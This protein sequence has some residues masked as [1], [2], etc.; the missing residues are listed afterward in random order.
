MKRLLM[1]GAGGI[2]GYFGGRL[3][4]NGVDVTFLV[5]EGRR[6]QL[7]ERGL[8]IHSVSGDYTCEPKLIVTGE[9]I[10]PYD[11]IFITVK[12]Y[13]LKEC[14]NDIEPY[15]GENT[16]IVPLL[17]GVSHMNTLQERFGRERVLGG[18][19]FIE[20]TLNEGGDIV[21]TSPANR[22]VY[23]EWEGGSSER[24]REL[25][26]LLS[27]TKANIESSSDIAGEMWHKYLFI[28]LLSGMTTIMNASVGPI[29]DAEYGMD[30]V[31]QLLEECRAVME[32][33]GAP[34]HENSVPNAI[35]TFRKVGAGMKASM[36]RDMEK[37]QSIEGEHLQGY[38]M[39]LAKQYSIP[40]PLLTVIYTR[41]QVYELQQQAK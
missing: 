36:L 15:V 32:A 16:L 18:L 37:S 17:N 29:R 10:Q 20:T 25:E 5:R 34:M 11:V 2:G 28:L 24:I 31:R 7:A 4:E 6:Q 23:G 13:H 9:E 8:V 3:V 40:V 30:L 27:G 19:C 41:L 14:M 33:A 38:M 22:L 39:E 1:V 12:A 21:Q 35:D 26:A